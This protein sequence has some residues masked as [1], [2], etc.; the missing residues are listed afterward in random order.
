MTRNGALHLSRPGTESAGDAFGLA[1]RSYTMWM[2]DQNIVIV[3]DWR[4]G[5]G[6]R[7]KPYSFIY[8]HSEVLGLQKH[9][10][11][12]FA[13]IVSVPGPLHTL[14]IFDA[15]KPTTNSESNNGDINFDNVL[16][17]LNGYAAET[18]EQDKMSGP[19]GWY[20]LEDLLDI[21]AASNLMQDV[22]NGSL[23]GN[24]VELDVLEDAGITPELNSG[25]M[26]AC[27]VTESS[28]KDTN[29]HGADI[30]PEPS[31]GD[32]NCGVSTHT[33]CP[34]DEPDQ[35]VDGRYCSSD[36][37]SVDDVAEIVAPPLQYRNNTV[38]DMEV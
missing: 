26:N 32:V 28:S 24:E 3:I 15:I 20:S 1:K 35:I 29:V 10:T 18:P 7:Y 21:D 30:A 36:F 12:S 33:S 27:M 9:L 34:A 11:Q 38:E 17:F 2:A 25:D 6:I 8:R 37:T 23:S 13:K 22:M 16:R 19:P 5:K 14:P 4:C 31:A